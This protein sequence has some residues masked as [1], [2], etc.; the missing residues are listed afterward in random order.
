MSISRIIT[1]KACSLRRGTLEYQKYVSFRGSFKSG[2]VVSL[3]KWCAKIV[4]S[5]L[6][7]LE[8]DTI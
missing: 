4:K 6:E 7:W 8:T 3:Q 2:S 1:C 5:I